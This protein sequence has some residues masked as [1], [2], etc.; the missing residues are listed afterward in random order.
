VWRA[1]AVRIGSSG[2]RCVSPDAPR[3]EAA[4]LGVCAAGHSCERHRRP[5][6]VMT[7]GQCSSS[8]DL[9]HV[10]T[11]TH[12]GRPAVLHPNYEAELARLRSGGRLTLLGVGTRV[13]ITAPGEFEGQVGKVAKIGRTSYHLR[14]G[15][16]MLRVPFALVEKA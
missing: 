5:E 8:F 13:R 6:R 7:C 14:A 16:T 11:W 2:E 4:W 9:A 12:H 10:F 15:R 1:I 3:V